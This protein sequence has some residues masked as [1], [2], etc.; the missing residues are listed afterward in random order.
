M[1]VM[2]TDNRYGIYVPLR[3]C[4]ACRALP[5]ADSLHTNLRVTFIVATQSPDTHVQREVVPADSAQIAGQSFEYGSNRAYE[6]A[7]QTLTPDSVWC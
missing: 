4:P 7:S 2:H 1:W 3:R 5:V 6:Q